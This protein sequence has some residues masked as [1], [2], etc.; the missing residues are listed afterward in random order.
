MAKLEEDP[1]SWEEEALECASCDPCQ[2]EVSASYSNPA[3]VVMLSPD[4][5]PAER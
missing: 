2:G 1:D 3:A 4:R 5:C